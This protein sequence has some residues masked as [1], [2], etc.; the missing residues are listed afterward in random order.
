MKI[1]VVISKNH[2]GIYPDSG[3]SHGW[4]FPR[5]LRKRVYELAN[6]F[7]KKHDDIVKIEKT[8]K[9]LDLTIMRK[10]KRKWLKK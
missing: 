9:T 10:D 8:N 3:H 1:K 4:S 7:K 5:C 2:V 6:D